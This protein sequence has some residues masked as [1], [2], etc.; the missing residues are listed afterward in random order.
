MTYTVTLTVT[1][2]FGDKSQA[3]GTINVVDVPPGFVPQA[4][5]APLTF[6][7]ASSGTGFG[8]SIATVQG[9]VAVGAPQGDGG[10]GAVE[11]YDGV[12]ND[13]AESTTYNYGELILPN[14]RLRLIPGPGRT[15]RATTSA[16]PSPPTA[17]TFW[18]GR[19]ART[20]ATAWF[21]SSTPIRSARHFGTLLATL[22]DPVAHQGG[23]FGSAIASDGTDIAVGAPGDAGGHGR[24]LS[25]HGPDDFAQLRRVP[26]RGQQP[27][28]Q[29]RQ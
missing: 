14:P 9:N 23:G 24:G 17:T 29:R 18:S 2:G 4:Y 7:P 3:T 5:E 10:A 26:V 16:R 8:T 20:G 22:N 6:T 28:W 25:L 27:G 21:L 15:R 19:P 11:L 13:D 12:P 1:D